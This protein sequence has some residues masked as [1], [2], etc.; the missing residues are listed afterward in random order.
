MGPGRVPPKRKRPIHH[1]HNKLQENSKTAPCKPWEPRGGLPMQFQSPRLR[2][3]H[4]RHAGQPSQHQ[5]PR[6]RRRNRARRSSNRRCGGRA[7][8]LDPFDPTA[9]AAPI[10][11]VAPARIAGPGSAWAAHSSCGSVPA[12]AAPKAVPRADS[13][14]RRRPGA[15]TKLQ[16]RRQST[17]GGAAQRP[18]APASPCP[19]RPHCLYHRHYH[20]QLPQR[21]CRS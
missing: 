2:A 19:R 1:Y 16:R 17:A 3:L 14:R 18:L 15:K 9:A 6:F 13:R 11:D 20:R 7:M 21:R 5:G 10:A 12:A 8:R 4:P